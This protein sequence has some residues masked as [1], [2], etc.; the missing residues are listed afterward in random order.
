MVSDIGDNVE[1]PMELE[2]AISISSDSDT[3][4]GSRRRMKKK[5]RKSRSFSGIPQDRLDVDNEEDQYDRS[6]FI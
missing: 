6:F 1:A 5:S 2:E 3:Q 4:T